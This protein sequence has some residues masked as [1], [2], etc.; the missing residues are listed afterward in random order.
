MSDPTDVGEYPLGPE[1]SPN[2]RPARPP[3][4]VARLDYQ[5]QPEAAGSSSVGVQFT[6]GVIFPW[7]YL[8]VAS[9]L[10]A[11]M[12]RFGLSE[13]TGVFTLVGFVVAV[14]YIRHRSQ[15][16]G[17]VP[18]VLCAIFVAPLVL[19]ATC[20]IVVGAAMGIGSIA[21]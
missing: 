16:T 5:R 7:V 3:I 13:V 4:R 9:M 21:G 12:W 19:L 2:P 18:G 15:W 6:L 14:T 8:M 17:F 11:V 1:P 10:S 20:A